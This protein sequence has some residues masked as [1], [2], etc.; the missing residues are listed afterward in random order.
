MR[1][2][3]DDGGFSP[4][5]FFVEHSQFTVVLFLM[6]IAVGVTS[7]RAIPRQED[8][9]FPA[10]IFTIIAVYP[11]A[12]PSDVEQLVVDPLEERIGELDDIKRIRSRVEDGLATVFVEF[13]V[14]TD[15]DRK[16]DEVLRELNAI[17]PDLPQDLHALRVEK[18]SS[19]EVNILQLAL[20]SPHAPFRVLDEDAR[21]IKRRLETVP[22]VRTVR[23]WGMPDREV[24]VALDLGRL[25]QLGIHPMHVLQVIGGE[26]ANV[27]GGSVDVAGRRF[28]VRTSGNYTDVQDIRRTVLRSTGGAVVTVQDVAEVEWSYADPT[29]IARFNGERA[30][31][32]SATQKSEYNIFDVR[33]AIWRELDALETALAPGISLERPFDQSR[34]VSARLSRLQTDFL[35]ALGLVLITLLPLGLRASGIVMIS[36]PLSLAIGI[37]LLHFAG[38][39]LNQLSIVGFVI[40][41]GLLVDDSIVVAENIGRHLREGHSRIQASILATRQISIAVIGSTATLILAF[42][43]LMF[44]P[45]M[46]GK[47]IRVLPLTV[48]LTVLASLF[49]SLTIIPWLAS[50]LLRE[51]APEGNRFMRALERAIHVTYAPLLDR[52]LRRPFLTLG[53]AGA[54]FL[55]SLALVPVVGFSLFPRA[56]T[57]QFMVDI[58]T[59]IGGSIAETDRAARFAESVLMRHGLVAGVMTNVGRDNPF[60]YYNAIPRGENAASAQLFVTLHGRSGR[61]PAPVLDSIRSAFALHA[62]ARVEL[63][64]FEQGPPIDAPIAIRITG[65]HL[66]TLRALAAGVEEVL[67]SQEGTQYVNNPVRMGRTDLRVAVDRRKAGLLG[68]QTLDVDRTVRLGLAGLTA[69][70]FR[71]PGGEEYAINVRLPHDGRPGPEALDRVYVPSAGGAQVPLRQ[72][73]DIRFERSTPAIEHHDKQRAVTVTAFV[74]EG[75]NTDRVTKRVVAALADLPLPSGYSLVAA[76]E[77][78]SR[79]ESFGGIGSAIIV[80]LFLILAILVLEFR[81][82][83]STLIVAS[84][85][86]L[87]FV[88]GIVALL[89]TGYT[90]SFTAT[91]GFVALL[92]I[93]IKTS[94]L[95]VDLANQL[96]GKGVSMEAAI[97][98]AGEVR[99]VPIVLTALTAIGGLLPLAL[100]G[101]SLYSPLAFVIIGGL[102]SST[103]LAR[104]VT[105]VMYKVLAP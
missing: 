58:E 5:K 3:S 85:I 93:E 47:F 24:R 20:V 40:A 57:P 9:T 59:P 84:V 46:A 72:V 92:G 99:F 64:E 32:I 91:I 4:S 65:E 21:R 69:G 68:V 26:N 45:G 104:L 29:H 80:A 6:L 96:R 37:T 13:F 66:D 78:E 48:I 18:Y 27:P 30:L 41:L 22:G 44:L 17:R 89:L 67:A 76:G 81:T 23:I 54:L 51:E 86:P 77:I 43:P 60:V 34:N 15:A 1:P 87:G 7:W 11:G 61:A 90:L 39:T 38:F 97:R 56:D 50:R 79:R 36:I 71:D 95:L 53:I 49:V 16:Y 62:G 98:R 103:L 102:I 19:S 10:P 31:F 105:P 100:A 52:S 12:S 28:N 25:A 74:R 42:L 73:A 83:R 70:W 2:G 8:P 101:S 14:S 82:F 75:Y 35:I 94:I 88:G 33:N 55:G 63:R